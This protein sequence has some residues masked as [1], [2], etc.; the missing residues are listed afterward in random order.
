MFLR[1]VSRKV[2]K[3][4]EN[5]HVKNSIYLYLY[6]YVLTRFFKK[7]FFIYRDNFP[8]MFSLFTYK[9]FKHEYSKI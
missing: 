9:F 3:V 5:V 2:K 8:Y 7:Y 6:K 1:F 4:T